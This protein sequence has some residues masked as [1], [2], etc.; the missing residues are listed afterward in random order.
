M[1]KLSIFAPLQKADASQRLVYGVMTAEAPDRAGEIMDYA[2]G[3]PAIQKWS[4][5]F[6][7]ATGGKSLG[8]VRLMHGR[9]VIGKVV[10]IQFDD[11]A[12]CVSVC[13]K[14]VDDA[15]WNMVEEGVLTGFSI[16]GGYAKRWAD[17]LHKRYT[18][19]LNELSLVDRPCLHGATFE[20]LKAD[21][22]TEAVALKGFEPGNEATK[23]WAGELAKAAGKPDRINDY[24][25][26]A[27][28]EL[29]KRHTEDGETYA[30][31]ED[32]TWSFAKAADNGDEAEGAEGDKAAPMDK[33]D[34]A[35]AV[36]EALA[37]A[38]ALADGG[39]AAEPLAKA[40]GPFADL[41]KLGP[42]L[43]ALR[44][45]ADAA[46]PLAKS[47]FTLEWLAEL[48]SGFKNLTDCMTADAFWDGVSPTNAEAAK[49][50]LAQI[51]DLFLA[52]A[53]E[54]VA[55]ATGVMKAASV[56]FT[57]ED[58]A[59]LELA[60]A[61]QADVEADLPLM[62]KVGARNN[63]TDAARIQTIH[64]H[65]CDLGAACAEGDV[66]EKLS[67]ADT[68]INRLTAALTEALPGI[69]KLGATVAAQQELL[70]KADLDRK[71]LTERL[72]NLE[73]Q[74]MPPK[75]Q[76]RALAKEDD[77]GGAIAPRQTEPKP[78]SLQEELA[79]CDDPIKRAAIILRHAGG[80]VPGQGAR[81]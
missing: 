63:K 33:I 12:K 6:A 2:T 78:G 42:V 10:D 74:P 54:E 32:D 51:G 3:K 36:A 1:D 11:L 70:A 49:T 25:G 34:A 53:R 67:K 52:T 73:K 35:D 66:V 65:A 18:P 31:G 7:E 68:E 8:N 4:E 47:L 29:I 16:G 23:A 41:A 61:A 79:K 60:K 44:A 76:I 57:S 13:A 40:D 17:G 62:E 9:T 24:V 30:K 64:D 45:Q 80:P 27:R 14:I 28:E 21:G 59:L 48:M 77:T 38:Q 5:S 37:K 69:E 15:A 46:D 71:A 19:A 26:P 20:M 56:E 43:V 72:A 58:G 39:Q 50:I 75:G 55:E 22:V 81:A